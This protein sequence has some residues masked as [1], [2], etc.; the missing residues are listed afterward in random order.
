MGTPEATSLRPYPATACTRADQHAPAP[1]RP[2]AHVAVHCAP[3]HLLHLLALT[4][5][6]ERTTTITINTKTTTTLAE[7]IAVSRA[8]LDAATLA[9]REATEALEVAT[10]AVATLRQNRRAGDKTATAS[11]LAT[12]RAAVS[13]AEDDLTHAEA[14]LSKATRNLINDDTSLADVI[15]PVL[16]SLPSLTGVE[17]LSVTETPDLPDTV[18]APV[19]YLVQRTAR[20]S[21]PI[22]GR[23]SGEVQVIYARPAWGQP[24]PDADDLADA[25]NRA[26]VWSDG[27]GMGTRDVRGHWED[28]ARIGVRGAWPAGLPVISSPNGANVFAQTLAGRIADRASRG[29][30]GLPMG[31]RYDGGLGSTSA[32]VNAVKGQGAVLSESSTESNSKRTTTVVADLA[33][34]SPSVGN[35][36]IAS[37]GAAFLQDLVGGCEAGLG[38]VET[39]E[40]VANPND[41]GDPNKTLRLAARVVFTSALPG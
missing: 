17:V 15:A 8:E 19:L 12:A 32:L 21:D 1:T 18:S 30:R 39:A 40:L 20:K 33:L 5:A 2:N 31:A 10:E 7:R 13:F 16:A 37:E 36:T 27:F 26:Q 35:S 41:N 34:W 29:R 4:R 25:L 38:R 28:H 14:R 24:L 3:L 11:D 23:I 6:L 9:A 22:S